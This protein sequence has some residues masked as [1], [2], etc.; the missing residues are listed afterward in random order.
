LTER[1]ARNYFVYGNFLSSWKKY[2]QSVINYKLAIEQYETI[3]AT[4]QIAKLNYAIGVSKYEEGQYEQSIRW[5]AQAIDFF[6]EMQLERNLANSYYYIGNS[7]K[8]IGDKKQAN[9][10]LAKSLLLYEKYNPAFADEVRKLL[11]P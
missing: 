4:D 6:E 2:S 5:I 9:D 7:Y 3:A 11:K 1:L 8:N 10:N